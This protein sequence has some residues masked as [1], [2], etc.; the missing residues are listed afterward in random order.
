MKPS[1]N[2]NGNAEYQWVKIA[3]ARKMESYYYDSPG[4]KLIKKATNGSVYAFKRPIDSDK[5]MPPH[6][7]LCNV[8]EVQRL[9]V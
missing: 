8:Y 4:Y 9:E 1:M 2:K 7:E 5:P 6:L 3:V